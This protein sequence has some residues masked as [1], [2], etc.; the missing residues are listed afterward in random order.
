MKGEK[1]WKWKGDGVGY[2]GLHYWVRRE[3]GNASYCEHCSGEKSQTF[4]W[5]NKSGLYLRD[6]IDWIRLCKSCHT[7]YD[8]KRGAS[9]YHGR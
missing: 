5:A 7:I 6:L 3:L 8:N 9:S 4:E 1:N 2:V